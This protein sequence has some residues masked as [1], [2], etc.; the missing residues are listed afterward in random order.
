MDRDLAAGV[1]GDQKEHLPDKQ[2]DRSYE[3]RQM[4]L[5]VSMATLGYHPA[6]WRLP[7]VPANGAM[8]WRHYLHV[9]Q[10]AERGCLDM[11]FLADT[12]ATRDLAVQGMAREREH[13][14]V[15]HDPH[16]LLSALAPLT[17]HIGLVAT[18]STTWQDPYSLARRLASL[19]HISGGRVGWNIVTGYS[20]DEARNH[21]HDQ[22]PDAVYRY[23]RAYEF[24][25]VVDGLWDSWDA[26]AFPRDK[27]SG[28]FFERDR[29]RILDHRGTHFAVRGPLDVARS[30]QGAPVRITAGDSDGAMELAARVAD[31]VY[32]GQ[33]DYDGARAYYE[34]VKSR[35]ALY[36]RPRDS[37]KIMP[38]IMAFV[39]RTEREARE[40]FE[41]LQAL[42]DPV[43]GLSLITPI[44]GDLSAY[45]L[46]GPV[47]EQLGKSLLKY[48]DY[49]QM[50]IA[51]IR[52]ENL[53]IR[54]LYGV[55][56]EGYWHLS[57]IGT[58]QRIADE[59]E[60]WF[61]TGA[62]DGFNILP[63]YMPGALE[64]FV[65]L[66]VPE[67]QRR[68]L[69]RTQYSGTTLREHLG[70][71]DASAVSRTERAVLASPP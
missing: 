46:D 22:V 17:H 25:K 44:F 27:A 34:A 35:M 56:A 26:D 54:Q 59:M 45:D 4:H 68:G 63:P 12:E 9:A 52:R 1:C 65:D 40:K 5:G 64:D 33:P 31:V 19:D 20:V 62:A 42:I 14:I 6:C 36:G 71:A 51:R 38:G 41:A 16:T 50:L 60:R 2:A 8:D 48:N 66:V 61:R 47:P 13:V 55:I 37:L 70:L 53:T 57:I 28:V 11:V 15:K 32:A 23:D 18:A 7:S 3:S 69:F 58:P 49:S 21:G 24:L 39:G 67:L 43:L 30:Q 29:M 10:T